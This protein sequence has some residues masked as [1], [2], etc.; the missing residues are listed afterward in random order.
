[1]KKLHYSIVIAFLSITGSLSNAQNLSSQQISAI[2]NTINE[3]MKIT[4]VPGVALAIINDNQVVLEK[5][6]G[7]A[8]T[9]TDLPMSDSTIFQIASLTKTFTAL[10]VLKELKDA[11]ID[12]NQ[13]IGTVITGLSPGLSSITFHQL[14]S[15]K[16]GLIEYTNETDR[17]DIY[18]FF[19]N[20]GDSI[21][22]IEPG[23]VFSYSNMGYA[24]IDL[25]IQRLSG[26]TYPKAVERN[27][28]GPLKLKN[29]GFDLYEV[30]SKSLATGHLWS[31]GKLTP[32]INH[33]DLPLLRAA[34]GLF[35]N[36]QDLERFALCLINEGMLEGEQVIDSVIIEQMCQPYSKDFMASESSYVI[37]ANWPDNAYGN[38]IIMFK[39]GEY[40]LIKIT[41]RI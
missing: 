26:L 28:F 2:E 33:F 22:F 8:N 5:G 39:Y 11:D 15:H 17:T 32:K 19:K 12:V 7:L 9:L 41:P 30:A 40:N 35:T 25:A 1:M 4:G 37:H 6:F 13:T 16:G 36:M 27:V 24:L 18:D 31:D 14:L 20:I 3:E 29:T 23:R 21:M 38:G 10:T 34:G